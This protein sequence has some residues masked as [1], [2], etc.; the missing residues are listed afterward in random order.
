MKEAEVSIDLWHEVVWNGE[1]TVARIAELKE[2][3]Q[4][5]LSDTGQRVCVRFA[6]V[7]AVDIS[8]L[9][10]LCSA[11]RTAGRLGKVLAIHGDIP[12]PFI[13]VMQLAGFNRHTGCGYDGMDNCIWME[14]YKRT[15][16][17]NQPQVTGP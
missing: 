3:L 4:E 9:Q 7:E 14:Q 16:I 5:V 11:H 1:L 15:N 8:L 17:G 10:L 6:E 2:E 12:E 13:K